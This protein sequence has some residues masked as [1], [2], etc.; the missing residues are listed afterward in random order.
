MALNK[1]VAKGIKTRQE[2]ELLENNKLIAEFMGCDIK[3]PLNDVVYAPTGLVDQLSMD[4]YCNA[5]KVNSLKFHSSWD[6]LM[7]VI[8]EVCN[9]EE[10]HDMG[11]EFHEIVCQMLDDNIEETYKTVIHTIKLI[12]ENRDEQV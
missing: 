5:V 7:P 12:N 3:T 2:N 10:V 11:L 8:K 4:H 9:T 6:W 1:N